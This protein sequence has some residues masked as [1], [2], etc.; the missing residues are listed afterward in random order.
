[1]SKTPAPKVELSAAAFSSFLVTALSLSELPHKEFYAS[2]TPLTVAALIWLG[3]FLAA[4]YKVRSPAQMQARNA[5]EQTIEDCES[6]INC[7]SSS[8]TAKQ[9]AE[10]ELEKAQLALINSNKVSF[11]ADS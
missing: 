8:T 10:E 4:K 11:K 2:G 6:I 5:A 9:K 1:M 3:Q 7:T